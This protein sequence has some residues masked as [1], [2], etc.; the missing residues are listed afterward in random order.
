MS[1]KNGLLFIGMVLAV[2]L[3]GFAG[4]GLVHD[5]SYSFKLGKWRIWIKSFCF[6]HFVEIIFP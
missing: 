6:K 2:A 5:L 4:Q 3:V 1:K